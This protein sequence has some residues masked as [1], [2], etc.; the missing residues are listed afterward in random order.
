[1]VL[2]Q[3]PSEIPWGALTLQAAGSVLEVPGTRCFHAAALFY[4]IRMDRRNNLF[5]GASFGI[6]HWGGQ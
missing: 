4:A 2:A 5:V 6:P 1:M 3:H